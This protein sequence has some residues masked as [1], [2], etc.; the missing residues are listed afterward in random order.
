MAHGGSLGPG[1]FDSHSPDSGYIEILFDDVTSGTSKATELNIHVKDC[2]G[3]N[4]QEDLLKLTKITIPTSAGAVELELDNAA[5]F[6]NHVH[7]DVKPVGTGTLL[8]AANVTENACSDVDFFPTVATSFRTNQYNA[9]YNDAQVLRRSQYIFEVDNQRSGSSVAPQNI[10]SILAGTAV[11]ASVQDSN[12][13]SNRVINGR[14]VGT[15]TNTADYGIASAL[16]GRTFQGIVYDRSLDDDSIVSQS[17]SATPDR[18]REFVFTIDP[19]VTYANQI[20]AYEVF[21]GSLSLDLPNAR[22]L[23]LLADNS[24]DANKA[25]QNLGLNTNGEIQISSSK[26]NTHHG[27]RSSAKGKTFSSFGS[28]VEDEPFLV[29]ADGHGREFIQANGTVVTMEGGSDPSGSTIAPFTQ[30]FIKSGSR[31]FPSYNNATDPFVTI[32]ARHSAAGTDYNDFNVNQQPLRIFKLIGDTI[33]E[34][35]G[36]QLAAVSDKKIYVV[37]TQEILY[38][39]Y[40]GMAILNL[41]SR[42]II[43]SGSAAT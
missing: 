37:D 2:G 11:T 41:G 3:T 13:S 9:V 14:Y 32:N 38:I 33:F 10:Q 27:T 25:I 1:Q 21:S 4:R 31:N 29:Q 18:I 42:A 30:I 20:G 36:N 39:D 26:L 6:T 40:R 19:N 22:Y 8:V 15:K 12:Y 17:D 23:R 43:S 5:A 28:F 35:K 34:S 24:S 7:F 16:S